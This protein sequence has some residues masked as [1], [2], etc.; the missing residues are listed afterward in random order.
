ME[1]V[2]RHNEAGAR[3]EGFIQQPQIR[4]RACAN[5]ESVARHGPGRADLR[6]SVGRVHGDLQIGQS[7]IADC[8]HDR[9]EHR[10]RQTAKDPNNR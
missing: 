2:G 3:G 1:K 4:D 6:R 9:L 5:I 7:S 8:F 10:R